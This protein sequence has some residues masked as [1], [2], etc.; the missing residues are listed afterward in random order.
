LQPTQPP[1][2]QH[3][4]AEQLARIGCRRRQAE[5]DDDADEG[6]RQA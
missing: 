5:G 4:V 3:K 6:Q 1:A 2:Q